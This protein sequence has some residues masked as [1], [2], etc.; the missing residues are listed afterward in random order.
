MSRRS[1]SLIQV[2]EARNGWIIEATAD[3]NRPPVVYVETSH[4]GVVKRMRQLLGERPP[5]PRALRVVLPVVLSCSYYQ[6]VAD[7]EGLCGYSLNRDA[8]GF[9]A[10]L[11]GELPP[12]SPDCPRLP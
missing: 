11:K 8:E 4:G 3:E 2:E 9:E 1:A 5:S 12:C 7:G 10:Q 6:R